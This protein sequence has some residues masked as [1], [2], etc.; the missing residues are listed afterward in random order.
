MLGWFAYYI[1]LAGSEW[2]FAKACN[3]VSAS[4]KAPLFNQFARA[5]LRQEATKDYSCHS[6]GCYKGMACF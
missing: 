3:H 5:L 2:F 6:Q 1:G 4:N